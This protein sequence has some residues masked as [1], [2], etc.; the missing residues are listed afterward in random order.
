MEDKH[1]KG[2]FKDYYSK[3]REEYSTYYKRWYKEHRER[4][5]EYIKNWKQRNPERVQEINKHWQQENKEH[6]NEYCRNWRQRNLDKARETAKK[7]NNKRYRQFSFIPLNKPFEGSEA[8]HI[9]PTFVIYIPKELHRSIK[10]SV[11]KWQNM[12]RINKLAWE[13]V[14]Q[15]RGEYGQQTQ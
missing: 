6:Y 15:Q 2:Y 9:C 14:Y 1:R 5:R 3:H 7:Y 11:L 12:N 8:H 10:H 13:V 4:R